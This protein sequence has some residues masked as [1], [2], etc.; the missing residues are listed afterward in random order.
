MRNPQNSMGNYSRPFL[1]AAQTV[2]PHR[3][4]PENPKITNFQTV[5][6]PEA[7]NQSPAAIE[8]VNLPLRRLPTNTKPSASPA[9]YRCGSRC[10]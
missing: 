7:T 2:D 6:P 9:C 3:P 8:V 10:S 4:K 5:T 1:L